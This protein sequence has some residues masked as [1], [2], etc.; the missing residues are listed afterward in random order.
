MLTQNIGNVRRNRTVTFNYFNNNSESSMPTNNVETLEIELKTT[1]NTIIQALATT[2]I[3]IIILEG[4]TIME[5]YL[6]TT[7]I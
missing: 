3:T 5:T 7:T 4:T 1:F 2:P 6:I